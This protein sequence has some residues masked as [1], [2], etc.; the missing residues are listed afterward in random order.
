M[1]E[2][3]IELF[4]SYLTVFGKHNFTVL[5]PLMEYTLLT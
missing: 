1:F 5:Y 4:F 3:N 2:K